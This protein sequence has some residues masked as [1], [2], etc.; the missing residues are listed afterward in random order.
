ML[1]PQDYLECVADVQS[2]CQENIERATRILEGVS[3][4][5]GY[6]DFLVR[7][8][9]ASEDQSV[10]Q[11]TS[12][13]ILNIV[14]SKWRDFTMVVERDWIRNALIQIA[15]HSEDP[16]Q[17]CIIGAI[18]CIAETDCPY[19]WNMMPPLIEVLATA[20]LPQIYAVLI[21]IRTTLTS[22]LTFPGSYLEDCLVA[23][24]ECGE[25]PL[26][27]LLL[28][29]L[30]DLPQSPEL[31]MTFKVL[32]DVIS[33]LSRLKFDEFFIRHLPQLFQC[34]HT[35]LTAS[36]CQCLTI[37]V[38][39]TFARYS[40]IQFQQIMNWEAMDT[41]NVAPLQSMF[42]EILT[43][44][45]NLALSQDSTTDVI[46]AA[47]K[48]LSVVS[49]S[50][51]REFFLC[52]DNLERLL[53]ESLIPKLVL[54]QQDLK[55]FE[56]EPLRYFEHNSGT[57]FNI[58]RNE[59]DESNRSDASAL[60]NSLSIAFSDQLETT[61][62]LYLGQLIESAESN[63]DESSRTVDAIFIVMSAVLLCHRKCMDTDVNLGIGDFI[64]SHLMP[65]LSPDNPSPF[66]QA[67]AI[68]F[69]ADFHLFVSPEL[70]QEIF[71]LIAGLLWS[72]SATVV[73][74]AA[75]CITR[76]CADQM[77]GAEVIGQMD[78]SELFRRLF[79]TLP[80]GNE[81]NVSSGL[82]ILRFVQQG[83]VFIHPL[84][85]D[86]VSG[87][88][89]YLTRMATAHANGDLIGVLFDI[90]AALVTK[91]GVD[92]SVIWEH[93]G[94]FL[95]NILEQ[96]F[97][98]YVPYA[99]QIFSCYMFADPY[100]ATNSFYSDQFH[101]FLD[102]RFWTELANMPQLA[103]LIRVYAIHLP[104]VV[105][106]YLPNLF[107]L[108]T[109]LLVNPFFL[110]HVFELFLSIIAFISEDLDISPILSF[111]SSPIFTNPDVPEF[112]AHFALFLADS[113]RVDPDRILGAFDQQ[114]LP[115]IIAFWSHGLGMGR[116]FSVSFSHMDRA[117]FP[118]DRAFQGSLAAIKGSQLLDESQQALLVKGLLNTTT[119]SFSFANIKVYPEEWLSTLDSDD[120]SGTLR[121]TDIPPNPKAETPFMGMFGRE[122][123]IAEFCKS[124]PQIVVQVMEGMTERTQNRFTR[125]LENSNPERLAP[126]LAGLF[127]NRFLGA[128][129]V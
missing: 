54:T 99:L 75:D 37:A 70:M 29:R 43:D 36:N 26:F 39:K 80:I 18:Q 100:A 63:P 53:L 66:L 35:F 6:L 102:P 82:C 2:G 57:G 9:F 90:L 67:D 32:L 42:A 93:V 17:S 115:T 108:C 68:K 87:V 124:K 56:S 13:Q 84:L 41:E 21:I 105:I 8:M 112:A 30:P 60:L 129:H 119:C 48:A 62:R 109:P 74:F 114:N 15:L 96:G 31:I 40:P 125:M 59:G 88:I 51:A 1:E 61:L 23:S 91:A 38:C 19:I 76:I 5:R 106:A 98:E 101:N 11:F 12:T 122:H 121:C 118:T 107:E 65:L 69:V 89:G 52:Q 46:C 64:R 72:E 22:H 97:T 113:C 34:Y 28:E 16:I 14:K 20:E 103:R 3:T 10:L 79:E 45:L 73:I 123:E 50:D 33:R 110:P 95:F 77:I 92:V 44:I 117:F 127:R 85:S 111:L 71:P 81:Y 78:L 27:Q 49:D 7:V 58:E 104:A 128:I 83:G 94:P 4:V 55:F 120:T 24:C 25:E 126:P 47:F 116:S 86:I